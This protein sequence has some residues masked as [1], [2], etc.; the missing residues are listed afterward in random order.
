MT[1]LYIGQNYA[2]QVGKYE[3]HSKVGN[4][5][6]G[7]PW[8]PG[9]IPG[10]PGAHINWNSPNAGAEAQKA[11]EQFVNWLKNHSNDY[12]GYLMLLRFTLEIGEHM[13]Q[14]PPAEQAKLS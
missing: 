14:L 7:W 4:G 8:G 10:D 6:D 13:G 5:G 3:V 12:N 2:E 1:D 11:Y 9:G